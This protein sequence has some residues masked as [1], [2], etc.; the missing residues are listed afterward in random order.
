M[1][2]KLVIFGGS[3]FVGGNMTRIA[4]KKGWKVYIADS[5]FRPGLE[6]VE[7]ITVNISDKAAVEKVIDEVMPDA[8]VN[9][10]AIADVD[11][12]EQE[13]ESAWNV[14]VEGARNI[15][16][17]C[18]KHGIKYIFFSS[19]AVFDGEG[20]DYIE[21]DKPKP[22]NYYG[23]TKAEAELA[24]LQAHPGA[25]VIRI[26]LVIGLPV[27]GGNSFLGGLE[28]KLKEGNEVHC[29]VNE[30]RTP[31]DVLTLCESVLE[32]AENDYTGILH[33]GATDS[34]NRFELTKKA[35]IMMGYD[36]NLVKLQSSQDIKP[37]RAPRHVNG[38][39]SVKKAQTVLKTE[40]LSVEKGIERAVRERLK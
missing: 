5:F 34:I 24:V 40:M 35:A 32:L 36:V 19:D 4:Q 10:A 8:V 14:N 25:V 1:S 33:I 11:K 7:W 12:A 38:I 31:I 16:G 6:D 13:K 18:V 15:A 39:I 37:G 21:D 3:G 20:R 2:K 29:P 28:A 27:T 30:V 26:S 17:S 23:K 22:V 9:V